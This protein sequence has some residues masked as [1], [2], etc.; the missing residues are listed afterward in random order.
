MSSGRQL[1]HSYE[2]YLQLLEISTVKLEY[3][4]GEIYAMAG[5]PPARAQLAARMIYLLR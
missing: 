4:A 5:G 3:Q 2:E 1:H